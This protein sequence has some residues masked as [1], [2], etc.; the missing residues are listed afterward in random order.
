[1]KKI[2]A[3]LTIL[4][5]IASVTEAPVV[6]AGNTSII[7]KEKTTNITTEVEKNIS[8]LNDTSKPIYIDTTKAYEGMENS[9]AD[10]YSPTI[11]NDKM[12]LVIPFIS[13]EIFADNKISVRVAFET[14]GVPFIYKNY[15][16]EVSKSKEGAYLY[17]NDIDLDANR[18]NGQYTIKVLISGITSSGKYIEDTYDIYINITDGLIASS[19]STKDVIDNNSETG[20]ETTTLNDG[21]GTDTKEP[22]RHQP[23][24]LLVENSLS[25]AKLKAGENY[26]FKLTFKNV[27]KQYSMENIKLTMSTE[28]AGIAFDETNWYIENISAGK[29]VDI[30]QNISVDL[31]AVYGNVKLNYEFQ[32]DDNEG[33]TYTSTEAINLFVTQPVKASLNGDT[34]P[35]KAKSTETVP[36]NFQIENSGLSPIY[37]A[38]VHIEGA[39]IFP[40]KELFWGTMEAGSSNEGEIPIY[41]GMKNMNEAG[42]VIEGE[43]Y[44]NTTVKVI[45]TYEDA[46]GQAVSEEKEYKTAIIKPKYN[47]KTEEK[48]STQWINAVFVGCVLLLLIVLIGCIIKM[49]HIKKTFI[50]KQ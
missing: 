5:C 2:I 19:D 9:F 38:R 37:N 35:Q 45:F 28:Y 40:T 29:S 15:Y 43:A 44:G 21:G 47:K 23:K 32:Y 4:I 10:G 41:I 31:K 11:E 25:A 20:D 24:V 1:M 36:M 26:E 42:E 46:D 30:S 49:I 12:H 13:S 7:S 48:K 6:A 18:I 50:Y 3:L 33:N 39:G 27:S 34:F 17:K 14:T 22:V 16:K 8:N